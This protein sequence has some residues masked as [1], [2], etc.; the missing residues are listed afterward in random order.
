MR[1]LGAVTIGQSPRSDVLADL[2]P[3][4]GQDVHVVEAG[5]LDGLAPDEVAALAPQPGE[6][7]L[8][9]RLRDGSS[10]R[11]AH[12]HI[13]PL[14]ARRV[15][16]L[17]RQVDAVLLLCTGSFPPF[18]VPCPVL[19]PDRLL[20]N[21]VRA[22][23]PDLHLGVLTPDDAQVEEQKSRWSEGGRRVTVRA[24]SPYGE[25]G[26]LLEAARDLAWQGADLVILD[27]LGY[28][29]ATKRLV[30]ELAGVPVIL[31]RTVLAR[32]AAELL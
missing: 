5:A 28:S 19:Y 22:L 4:I 32:A 11:V 2:R 13:L 29:V 24:A 8:V 7:V 10:V 17:A 18:Q 12:R 3:V 1:V 25:P 27:S 21:F 23:A 31:P 26:R 14:L 30:R 6:A 9:T 15:E 16:S 20:R